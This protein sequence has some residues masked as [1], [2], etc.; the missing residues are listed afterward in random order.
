MAPVQ[1]GLS[2][3]SALLQSLKKSAEA[4]DMQAANATLSQLK[5]V[6]INFP[7]LPPGGEESATA[8]AERTLAREVL[9][10]A[11]FM[12]A[13]QGDKK[14]LARHMAQLKPY[15][16]DGQLA[17]SLP[18]SSNRLP[19]LG[20]NLIFLLV[21]NKLADFHS[22]LELM[23]DED[24]SNECV[25]FPIR[26]EQYLM[27]GSYNQVLAAKDHVPHQYY[28]YLLSNL[29]D[30]VREAIADCMSTAY[31]SMSVKD[32]QT[33]L[34]LPASAQ[35]LKNFVATFH[36]EWKIFDDKVVFQHAAATKKM[37]E[38]PSMRVI[39]ETLSYATE[40]ER[41]V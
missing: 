2:Q 15:Y 19:L 6:L 7:S 13:R 26:L 1:D 35:E 9:E 39:T 16:L 3:G 21:E 32:A 28:S 5:L 40:L 22:E 25:M 24:R 23:S 12:S 18:D 38:I 37:Q 31:D 34:M 36:P 4:G 41:I 27:V 8:K 30:T 33:M 20:L 10:V 11:V 14:A 17:T 29:V